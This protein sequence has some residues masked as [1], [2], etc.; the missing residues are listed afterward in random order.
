MESQNYLDEFAPEALAVVGRRKLLPVWMKIFIWIFMVAGAFVVPIIMMGIFGFS[1]S[2]AI[3]G[4]E[5]TEPTST[6]GIF[7]SLL[8]VLKGLVSYGL[9]FEKTWAINLGLF[10]AYLGIAI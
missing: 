8:F 9:W 4:F 2:L 3:Y 6:V 7:I 5:T 10:D 1:C